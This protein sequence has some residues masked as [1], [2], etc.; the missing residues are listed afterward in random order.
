MTPLMRLVLIF[1]PLLSRSISL[2]T[3]FVTCWFN[4]LNRLS[5]QVTSASCCVQR[6]RQSYDKFTTSWN[7]SCRGRPNGTT[8]W[9]SDERQTDWATNDWPNRSRRW[10]SCPR[11]AP[12]WPSVCWGRSRR[13]SAPCWRSGSR[14]SAS[15]RTRVRSRSSAP[16]RPGWK[17]WRK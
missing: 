6:E 3:A 16:D 12:S 1:S 11:P 2:R 13:R 14:S 7:V 10:T 15:C 17:R 9:S 8:D 4:S 5:L